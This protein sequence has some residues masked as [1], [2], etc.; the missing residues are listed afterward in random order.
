MTDIDAEFRR[1]KKYI[2][3]FNLE[4]DSQFG[5]SA[6][7]SRPRANTSR[8]FEK[9]TGIPFFLHPKRFGPDHLR[10]GTLFLGLRRARRLREG[11]F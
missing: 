2:A 7:P 5:N 11:A 3:A 10:G 8:Y 4:N 9:P 6:S 1:K